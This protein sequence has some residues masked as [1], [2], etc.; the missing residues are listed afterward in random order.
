MYH[1][2]SISVYAPISMSLSIFISPLS[3][4][5]HFPFTY[6]SLFLYLYINFLF[7][8]PMCT[9]RHQTLI[10]LVSHFFSTSIPLNFTCLCF[11][12]VSNCILFLP[13]SHYFPFF[14]LPSYFIVSHYLSIPAYLLLCLGLA[15][16][17][18]SLYTPKFRSLSFL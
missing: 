17:P 6:I 8:S 5:L 4:T 18:L 13:I 10:T 16:L 14:Y 9:F 1:S 11:L 12:Y 7:C 15:F 2:Q 3:I